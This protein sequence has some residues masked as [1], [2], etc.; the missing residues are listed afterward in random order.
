MWRKYLI[1]R[2]QIRRS[3]KNVIIRG[4]LMQLA[5]LMQKAKVAFARP[6]PAVNGKNAGLDVF[7]Y[8]QAFP[9]NPRK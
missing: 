1:K 2:L 6:N 4:A 5:T 7:K 3:T 8:W 9:P